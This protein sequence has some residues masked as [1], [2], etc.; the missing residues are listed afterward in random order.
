MYN[1]NILKC[2]NIV[3]S[4]YYISNIGCYL[5]KLKYLKKIYSPIRVFS[6][7][8]YKKITIYSFYSI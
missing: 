5:F 1:T 2:L 6:S 4:S 8:V 3:F 7:I